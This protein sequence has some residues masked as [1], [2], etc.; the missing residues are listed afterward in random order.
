[1]GKQERAGLEA[2]KYILGLYF[3]FEEKKFLFQLFEEK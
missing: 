3:L 2:I 1:M